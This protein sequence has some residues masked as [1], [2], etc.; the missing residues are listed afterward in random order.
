[1]DRRAW[2]ATVLGVEKSQMRLKQVSTHA[3]VRWSTWGSAEPFPKDE[4][5]L[6]PIPLA[7]SPSSPFP[8]KLFSG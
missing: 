5:V 7:E 4:G 2:R 1:M 6:A 3:R 8:K